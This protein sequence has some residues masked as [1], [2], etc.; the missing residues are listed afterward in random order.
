MLFKTRGIVIS[1]IK[2]RES[3]IILKVFT[4]EFGLQTY[5]VNGVRSVKSKGKMALYQPLTLLDMVV[6]KND[7]KSIQR[8]SECRC[9]HPYS[10]APFDI[11]KSAVLM[12]WA[13]LLSKVIR[14]EGMEERGKFKFI[15]DSLINLDSSTE[16][17]EHCPVY[18]GIGMA[19]FIGFEIDSALELVQDF[20]Y[21]SSRDESKLVRY[22]DACLKGSPMPA[23]TVELRRN[24][25]M[26]LLKFYENH[27]DDFREMKSLHILKQL[28]N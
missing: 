21:I 6:Y 2:F 5:V 14:D 28:F 15:R 1:H 19:R 26:C 13:E 8:I 11:K 22:F 3:S 23:T 18:F 25:L 24:A 9:E 10:Q 27:L 12:F 7:Q 17:V 20:G 4:E 16:N